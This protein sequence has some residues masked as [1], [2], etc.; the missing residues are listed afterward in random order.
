MNLEEILQELRLLRL[1]NKKITKEKLLEKTSE[2][3]PVSL[4]RAILKE[5]LFEVIES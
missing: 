3:V 2:I 4:W 1:E 5:N